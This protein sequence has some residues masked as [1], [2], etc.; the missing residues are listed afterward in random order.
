MI[1]SSTKFQNHMTGKY[2]KL[3]ACCIPVKGAKRSTICDLQRNRFYFIPNSLFEILTDH[4]GQPI[5]DIRKTYAGSPD[6]IDEYVDFLLKKELAFFTDE[7]EK[8]PDLN[9]TWKFPSTI[10][11]AIIE[12][13]E[14]STHHY[15]DL[16][17]QLDDLNCKF[18]QLRCYCHLT[19]DDLSA[20][21]QATSKGRAMSIEILIKYDETLDE[22]PLDKFAT[23]FNEHKRI[24]YCVVHSAPAEKVLYPVSELNIP[25]IF[26]PD[27]I[28]SAQHCGFI[29]P[30]HFTINLQ[31]FTESKQYNNC[32]N[33][34]ISIDK[35]GAIKNCP[36]FSTSYGNAASVKLST[37]A[38]D[39]N[40]KAIW[41]VNKDQI[42]VCSDCEFRYICTDCRV[43]LTDTND[44]LSKPA[45][46][47]YN[48]YEAKWENTADDPR[49]EDY[50]KIQIPHH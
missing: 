49:H 38:A 19:P 40:F 24:H 9:L 48:P 22:P 35:D 11:N 27:R 1:V 29:H 20:I 6:I 12:V 28:D 46:C 34:K 2:L 16:F 31:L 7:P 42:K 15:D 47:S 44:P 8:F 50:K 41:S 43:F 32:L 33:R 23:L 17:Q 30:S 3:F 13:D 39:E 45:R 36:A 5:A 21:L 26:I 25:L 14:H 4:A 10:T 37:V 18:I